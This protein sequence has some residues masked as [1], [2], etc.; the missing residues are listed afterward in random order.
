MRLRIT[1]EKEIDNIIALAQRMVGLGSI[2]HDVCIKFDR[3]YGKMPILT[4]VG[5]KGYKMMTI[6]C[7]QGSKHPFIMPSVAADE[8]EKM[9][10]RNDI[11]A[12]AK[13][14]LFKDFVLDGRSRGG[15][16]VVCASKEIVVNESV[17]SKQTL[18]AFAIKDV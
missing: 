12:D 17:S 11:N 15:A 9:R 14:A 1:G 18:Y 13:I 3:G 5:A 2:R 4:T 8:I 16:Q 10:K 6:A 7:E